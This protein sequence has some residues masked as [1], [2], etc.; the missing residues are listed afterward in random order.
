MKREEALAG[1]GDADRHAL[2]DSLLTIRANLSERTGAHAP[3][4]FFTGPETRRRV[5]HG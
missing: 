2:I 3:L 5:R 1:L 4:A